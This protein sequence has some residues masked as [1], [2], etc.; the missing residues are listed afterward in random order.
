[1]ALVP[2]KRP[3]PAPK[4][5]T[6]H[7]ALDIGTTKI[8]CLIGRVAEHPGGEGVETR[9]FGVG[10]HR[11]RGVK[12]GTVLDMDD[13]VDAICAT[14][15]AAE[16]MAGETIH[17]VALNVSHP[18]VQCRRIQEH[19]VLGNG[20]VGRGEMRRVLRAAHE[21]ARDH[22][23]VTL[24]AIPS[25]YS[26]DGSKGIREPLGM[27]GESLSVNLNEVS[28]APGPLRNLSICVERGHLDPSRAVFSGYAAALASMIEDELELGTTLIEMG[29]ATTSVASFVDGRLI[30]AKTLGIGGM[31]VTNDLAR[32][33]STPLADAERMKV[34]YGSTLA[35]PNDD[36]EMIDVPPIG[37]EGRAS[38]NHVPRSMLVG[39]IRPRVE[40]TL[41]II[42][43]ELKASGVQR[44]AGHRIVL[45]GGACQLSGLRE[46]AG[47]VFDGH[48]RIGRPINI[49][50]L[51]EA[52][53]GPAFATA[54][55][56]LT[57][58]YRAPSEAAIMA[59]SQS[60]LMGLLRRLSPMRA[61]A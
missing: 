22:N 46:F 37:D 58:P 39:I 21:R 44:V 41:E 61:E 10:H 40:E 48:V 12:A 24:H 42:R 60:G 31:H 8:T 15:E 35:S 36:R 54:A 38:A 32:G 16:Q 59:E 13:A 4:R 47:R 28:C 6:L 27:Q 33:L 57:F 11:S 55:G 9:I 19:T 3:G 18:S 29:G 34:L 26:I 20:E 49:L 50:G 7:A 45:T 2:G 25:G 17:Q 43:D 52:T 53:S 56:L 30:Y 51:P 5:G 14:V 23:Q 1:M